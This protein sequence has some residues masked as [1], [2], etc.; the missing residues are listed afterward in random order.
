[1]KNLF[2]SVAI[3]FL[4]LSA[5]GQGAVVFNNR[6]GTEVNA[7]VA[8][9]NQPF[10]GGAGRGPG[11]GYTAQLLLVGSGGSLTPLF[12]TTT[13]RTTSAAAGFFI[14]GVDVTIPGVSPGSPA[15]LRMVVW[16]SAYGSYEAARGHGFGGESINFTVTTGGGLL[17]PTNLVGLQPFSVWCIP[18]P[19]TLGRSISCCISGPCF[20]K[21]CHLTGYLSVAISISKH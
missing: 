7:G 4:H 18:E 2:C 3:V 12:P 6:V 9:I 19:S 16:L 1:M 13:F 10:G 14:N 15:T 20:S 21:L 5:F 17:P 11:P 8:C